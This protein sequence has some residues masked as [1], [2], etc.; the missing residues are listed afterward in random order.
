MLDPLLPP[1]RSRTT[2]G[3]TRIDSCRCREGALY[4]GWLRDSEP[5]DP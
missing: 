3:E 4:C 2:G 1:L 5:R